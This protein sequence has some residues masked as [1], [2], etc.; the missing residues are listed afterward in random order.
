MGSRLPWVSTS[1]AKLETCFCIFLSPHALLSVSAE[2]QQAPHHLTTDRK[3]SQSCHNEGWVLLSP[4]SSPYLHP[5][6]WIVQCCLPHFGRKEPKL[7]DQVYLDLKFPSVL[8]PF[9][10]ICFNLQWGKLYLSVWLGREPR[11]AGVWFSVHLKTR[12]SR[13]ITFLANW[14]QTASCC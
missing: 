9:T 4:C 12:H 13:N 11:K 10:D 7:Q 3:S 1:K 14:S 8:Y 5:Y 2:L 6:I